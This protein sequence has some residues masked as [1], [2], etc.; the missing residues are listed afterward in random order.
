[1]SRY[2]FTGS[3]PHLRIVVGWDRPL[4][5]YFAQVWDGGKL[6][7]G[8]LLLWA[9]AGA[10]P[11][12]TVEDLAELLAPFGAIPADVASQLRDEIKKPWDGLTLEKLLSRR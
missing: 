10:E 3:Q 9:G 4:Q 7:Q 6:E 11:V 8:N 5:T 12:P 2:T 1:M